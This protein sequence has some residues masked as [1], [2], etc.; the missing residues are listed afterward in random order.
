M[1]RLFMSVIGCCSMAALVSVN[2]MP[3]P[4]TPDGAATIQSLISQLGSDEFAERETASVSLERIGPP[5]VDALWVATHSENPE[6]RERAAALL[7]KIQRCADSKIRLAARRVKLSYKDTPIGTA[8]NDL[9]TQTGLNILLDPNRVANPLRR[10]T[11]ETKEL[12]VWEALEV[13]CSAAQLREVFVADFDAPK[14]PNSRRGGGYP[15][16][17][18]PPPPN[19]DSIPVVLIDGKPDRLP[20]DRSTSVRIV[21]L[22]SS[23]PGHK[24]TLGSGEIEFCL[25]VTPTSGLAWQEATGVKITRVIDSSGRAGAAGTE[26]SKPPVPD[27]NNGQFVF[28]RPGVAMRIDG[29]VNEILPDT[30]PNP[31]VIKVPLKVSTPTA[32]HLKRLEG[33]VFGEIQA[34]NQQLISVTDP[35][36]NRNVEFSGPGDLKFTILEVREAPGPGGRGTIRV[37]LEY[38]SPWM[39]NFRKRGGLN[40]GWPDAPRAP[41]QVNRLEVF[42]AKGK[43]FPVTTTSVTD[44]NDDGFVTV[45]TI[46]F[47]FLPNIGL[48]AKIVVVGPKSVYVQVPFV[49][50]NV[51]LP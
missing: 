37:Q 9:R 1:K 39:V 28:V 29:T 31:R 35:K 10:V 48:P 19:A 23:F 26:K 30:I 2:G 15:I 25:D 18:L 8:L 47:N 41:S 13:F 44:M 46:Q 17:P 3:V 42:D 20:G 51:P 34:L 32:T 43:T 27:L 4:S 38:P 49:L 14:S 16:T 21:A 11:C 33:I 24:V 40:F 12:P 5:A 36:N 22:P 6:V 45:Q 50:E 7:G